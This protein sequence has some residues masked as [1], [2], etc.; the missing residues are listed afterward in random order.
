MAGKLSNFPLCSSLQHLLLPQLHLCFFS[1]KKV[2][3]IWIELPHS[4]T[5]QSASL[6]LYQTPIKGI[7]S[8]IGR[9]I[10]VLYHYLHVLLSCFHRLHQSFSCQGHQSNRKKIRAK[11]NP[12]KIKKQNKTWSAL[13]NAC[14]KWIQSFDNS[15]KLSPVL[16]ALNRVVMWRRVVV[17]KEFYKLI[18]FFLSGNL[19][20]PYREEK[21]GLSEC[22]WVIALPKTQ[23]N[24]NQTLLW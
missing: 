12:E 10:S 6:H 5:I 13:S 7:I 17:L 3:A 19:S 14:D 1:L 23:S 9:N 22:C 15:S 11:W 8:E 4:L 24:P 18:P 21:S 20:N 16:R 2:E